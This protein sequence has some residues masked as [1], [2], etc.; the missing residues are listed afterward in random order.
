MGMGR[1]A[2]PGPGEAVLAALLMALRHTSLCCSGVMVRTF[3]MVPASFPARR[4]ARW[5][6][7]WQASHDWFRWMLVRWN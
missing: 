3:R 4:C 7:P 5:K 6:G 2:P 1:R